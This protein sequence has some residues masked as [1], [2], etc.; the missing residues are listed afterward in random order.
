MI[1]GSARAIVMEFAL[2]KV[3]AMASGQ[4]E[5]RDPDRHDAGYDGRLRFVRVSWDGGSGGFGR[6]G[7]VRFHEIKRASA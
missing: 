5:W 4:P 3:S 7:P 2:A 6:R 1:G